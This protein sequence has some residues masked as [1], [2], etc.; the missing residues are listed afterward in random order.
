MRNKFLHVIVIFILIVM[1]FGCKKEE[2]KKVINEKDL[3][4]TSCKELLTLIKTW[5]KEENINICYSFNRD[6]TGTYTENKIESSFKYTIDETN[7]IID[8][9]DKYL[10]SCDL[11]NN[12]ITLSN[13]KEMI[14]YVIKGTQLFKDLVGTKNKE[15]KGVWNSSKETIMLHNKDNSSYGKYN[16]DIYEVKTYIDW[17]NP[18]KNMIIIQDL[19]NG[20][21]REYTYELKNNKLKLFYDNKLVDTYEK[22][23]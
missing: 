19:S 9:V 14:T 11:V 22:G 7:L 23:K 20:K 5:E 17:V 8:S 21:E 2:Q 12:T 18:S 4:A 13:E 10:V 15:L 6:G 1:L 3:K 16:K